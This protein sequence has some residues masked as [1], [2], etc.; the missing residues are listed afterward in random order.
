[1]FLRKPPET[2]LIFS[3]THNPIP[4]IFT[5]NENLTKPNGDPKTRQ[6]HP[7]QEQDQTQ[8]RKKTPKAIDPPQKS[9]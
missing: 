7:K 1:K 2:H 5:T 9:P 8:K 3:K 6:K 4:F